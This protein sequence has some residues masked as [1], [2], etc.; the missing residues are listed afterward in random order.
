MGLFSL[1]IYTAHPDVS[2]FSF[3][4]IETTFLAMQRNFWLNNI[5]DEIKIYNFGFYS[6]QADLEFFVPP[7]SEAASLQP[8]TDS[9]YTKQ[10][11]VGQPVIG[12]EVKAITCHVEKLDDFVAE[13]QLNCL[14][15]VKC[16]VEGA[17]K[18]VFSGAENILQKYQPVIYTEMLRKHAKRFGYHP[19][20]IIQMFEKWGYYC[21]RLVNGIYL[22][23][24]ITMDE[25]TEETNF[26]FLHQI[27]H[28]NLIK[29]YS[30]SCEGNRSK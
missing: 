2:L 6:E 17:E 25:Q 13:Q 29:R 7:C 8:I 3:E 30:Y 4:P 5:T 24:F 27:K 1:N 20:E 21:Y 26:F 28:R 22:Q 18:M 15:F 9:Y 14:D 11:N 12:S 10:G 19:N 16:D 23:R